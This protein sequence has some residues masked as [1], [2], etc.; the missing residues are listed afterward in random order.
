MS[1]G[2]GHATVLVQIAADA[3]Q[4]PVDHIAV[5]QGDTRQVQ[6]GH[7]TFNSRSMA[8]VA[9]SGKV[10]RPHHRQGDPDTSIVD[11]LDYVA[12]DDA[13]TIINPLLAAS[14]IHGGV[15][16]GIGQALYEGVHYDSQTGQL[17]TGSLLDYAVPRADV[18]PAIRS[19]FQETPSPTNP[20]GVRVHHG[21]SS[22]GTRRSSEADRQECYCGA[23][24]RLKPR[25]S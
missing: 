23:G 22:K 6:A 20:L 12:V 10:C 25:R 9:S 19:H 15:A 8:V 2:H 1:Q 7:G 11:I 24:G 18:L 21:P 3:L 13:G 5:V 16:Q 4:I 14:Q 17:L